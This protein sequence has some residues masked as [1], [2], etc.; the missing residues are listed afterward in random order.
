MFC[1]EIHKDRF[2]LIERFGGI[3][4]DGSDDATE[5]ILDRCPGGVD[6]VFEAAGSKEL[7]PEGVRMLRVGGFYGW[8]GLVHPDSAIE[9]NAELVIRK[10]LTLRGIHN[11]RPV[12]L[13]QAVAFL[14]RNIDR[15]PFESL[16]SP[17]APLGQLAEAI[18]RSR[19]RS[20]M[21]VSL[22]P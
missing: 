13:E 7:L 1:V 10:C 5:L 4:V 18:E 21:R 22:A 19:Q 16:V 6:A 14:A 2:P 15:L 20:F 8:I 9:V 11:Y 12:D 3:P 17:P